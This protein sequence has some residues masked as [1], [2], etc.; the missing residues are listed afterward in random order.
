MNQY[1]GNNGDG[2]FNHNYNWFNASGPCSTAPCD[3]N[4]HGTHTMGTMAGDDGAG[5]QIGVA[6]GATW[7]AANGCCPS[8][9]ALVASG[10][11]MLAPTDL[12]DGER[13]T[14]A[15]RPN[16]VNNSWGT[17]VPSNAP[18]MEDISIAWAAAGIFG[19]FSNGN[20]GPTRDQRLPRQPDRELLGGRLRHRQR[21]RGFSAR[22]AGQD[23]ETKPNISAPGVNV[24]SSLPGSTYGAFNGTSM[25]APHVAGTVALLWSAAPALVG[26][27]DATRALLDGSATDTSNAACGGTADDNN[28]WGEGRLDAMALMES[29][30][31]GDTG[32]L[33]GTVTESGSGDPIAGAEVAVDGEIDRTVTTDATG[34]YSV[35][36]PVGDYSVTASAFGY[37]AQT[38]TAIITVDQTTTQDFALEAAP[39]VSVSG[40][41]KDGSGHDWPLYAKVDVTGPAGDTWTEPATGEYSLTLP[42]GATYTV[43]VTSD[44]PG[45]LSETREITVGDAD[46]IQDYEL[47][48]DSATCAAAGYQF[49]TAGVTES[50][51]ATTTPPG[52]TVVDDIGNGQVWRFDNPR[53]RSNLT[54]GQGN[55][56]IMDSDFYG[57]AGTQ[58]ASLVSPVV[59][60]SALAAARGRLLAGLQQPRGLRRRRREHRRRGDLG[61]GPAPDDRRCAV[62]VRT[63][64]SCRWRPASPT[65]RS[66]STTT[67]RTSTGG[68]RSTTCSSATAP[69]TRSVVAWSSETSGAPAARAS[70]VP[71]SPA[72]TSPTRTRPARRLRT[73][74]RSTTV[75]TGCS[76]P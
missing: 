19:V 51:D 4:G 55:F 34:A 47:Q 60:M 5:N 9:A 58:N 48:V 38:T 23:G 30:P 72:W 50:F 33:T 21:H 36:L 7:I 45:Y 68:G 71:P 32:I 22:G 26:D 10:E 49:D 46:V 14:P 54:G 73:T 18:F 20:S 61:D 56:A 66:A 42:A 13:P 6:P 64:S 63:S 53:G 12:S 29:A 67:R 70:T 62:R 69:V 24:R 28:V 59:D 16:I 3:T 11:W 41:V 8:D 27:I 15:K 35:T 74:R 76:R 37:I 52:W 40:S 65:S 43:T 2:T 75:S 17:I 25:A 44:Y 31:I 1:R 39:S 57:G